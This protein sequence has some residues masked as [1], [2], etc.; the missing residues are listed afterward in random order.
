MELIPWLE[1]GSAEPQGLKR[2]KA[3][4]AASIGLVPHLVPVVVIHMNVNNQT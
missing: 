4:R 3:G 1:P 2:D